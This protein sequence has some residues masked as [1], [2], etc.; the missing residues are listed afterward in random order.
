MYK[1]VFGVDVIVVVVAAADDYDDDDYDDEDVYDD[2][3]EDENSVYHIA[4]KIL[5]LSCCS[6]FSLCAPQNIL[7][8]RPRALINA[9]MKY[10]IKK[11]DSLA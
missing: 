6:K 2:L 11:P 9:Y 8:E 4:K 3:D 10:C 1:N 5:K 7:T